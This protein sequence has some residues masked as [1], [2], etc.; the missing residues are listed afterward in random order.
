MISKHYLPKIIEN[1]SVINY[2]DLTV[3]CKKEHLLYCQINR[4][5]LI[6][7]K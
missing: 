3:T 6:S 4:T 1:I 7:L 5:L 2:L